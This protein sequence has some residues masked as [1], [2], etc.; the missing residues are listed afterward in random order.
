MSLLDKGNQTIKVF[1]AQQYTSVDGN[2][3]YRVTDEFETVTECVVQVSA[4]SGTSAR[5]AEQEDEGYTT[6]E[7]YRLRP[8]RRY[9]TIIDSRS[10]VEWDGRRWSVYGNVK[11]FQ[12][13]P[14][15]N[16]RDYTLRRL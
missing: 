6:E 5:R 2:I 7:V 10:Q 9:T 1:H 16:H 11:T 14:R 13:G 3:S 12:G 8:P 4:Q 15:T